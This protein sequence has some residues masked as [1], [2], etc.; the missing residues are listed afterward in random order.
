[1]ELESL[2]RTVRLRGHQHHFLSF[3]IKY[4]AFDSV[5]T[6]ELDKIKLT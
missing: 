5:F 4:S 2:G 3:K 6:N 1:M